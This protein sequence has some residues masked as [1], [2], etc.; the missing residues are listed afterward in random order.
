MPVTLILL[1]V[2]MGFG[3]LSAVAT[4][5]WVAAGL[6]ALAVVGVILGKE[7]VRRLLIVNA[8]GN[9]AVLGTMLALALLEHANRPRP[10]LVLSMAVL[11]WSLLASGFYL[12]CLTRRNVQVWMFQRCLLGGAGLSQPSYA[13]F[14]APMSSLTILSMASVT[15]LDRASSSVAI[16]SSMT[17]GTICQRRP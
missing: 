12:W 15:R 14:N 1:V 3:V 13:F 11:G 17:A 8:I 16:I 7:G 6:Q 5:S 10:E 4:Q 2:A 9:L